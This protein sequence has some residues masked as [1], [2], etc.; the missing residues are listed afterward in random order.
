MTSGVYLLRDPTTQE[1]K[2][3]GQS[4]CI[5]NRMSAHG[6]GYLLG[7][8]FREL[9][10]RGLRPLV[11]V[12]ETNDPD[13]VER[14]AIDAFSDTVLN[15]ASGGKRGFT[16]LRPISQTSAGSFVPRSRVLPQPDDSLGDR[17]RSLGY[18]EEQI[19]EVI[20]RHKK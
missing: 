15:I 17:L 13:K 11:D 8:W 6:S 7:P 10:S 3:V 19:S 4:I 12:I 14:F 5:E 9:R 20:E 16:Y 2:Y 1:I 18:G